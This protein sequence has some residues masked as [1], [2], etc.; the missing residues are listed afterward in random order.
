[1]ENRIEVKLEILNQWRPWPRQ[2]N[3]RTPQHDFKFYIKLGY[4][5]KDYKPSSAIYAYS[6]FY[7]KGAYG[8]H[9][10][11]LLPRYLGG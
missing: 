1:M 8:N 3:Y 11:Y 5:P 10:C 7:R 9:A 6:L 4:V 2:P